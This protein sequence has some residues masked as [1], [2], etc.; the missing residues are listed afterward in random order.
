MKRKAK[1]IPDIYE[2]YVNNGRSKVATAKALGV[3]F[4]TVKKNLENYERLAEKSISEQLQNANALAIQKQTEKLANGDDKAIERQFKYVIAQTLAH[5][6]AQKLNTPNA[7]NNPLLQLVDKLQK[8]LTSYQKTFFEATQRF[9]GILSS[10][11]AGKT[12]YAIFETLANVSTLN[13]AAVVW[14]VAP[15]Y[16]VAKIAF[17]RISRLLHEA[18]IPVAKNLAELQFTFGEGQK[19]QFKSAENPDNLYGEDVHFV[20]FDEF[21][22]GKEAAWTAIYS[23]L[24]FTQGRAVLIGN[25]TSASNW[26]VRL[27]KDRAAE[28]PNEYAFFKVT[29]WEAVEA[30]VLKKEVVEQA[31]KDLHKVIF[32]A[33]YLVEGSYDE[34]ALISFDKIKSV[35]VEKIEKDN[36][37]ELFIT[38]DIALMGS[39][40]FVVIV[41][42]GFK[43]LE[44]LMRPKTD[45]NE[46]YEYIL[47]LQKKY[48][49]SEK[50]IAYDA[51]GAGGYLNGFLKSS[52]AFNGNKPVKKYAN[53]RTKCYFE[54]SNKINAN[55]LQIQSDCIYENEIKEELQ[56]I[57]KAALDFEGK[58]AIIKK[59]RMREI[60]KRSPDFADALMMRM[61][62]EISPKTN[63]IC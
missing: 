5:E 59:D 46:V 61:Y 6:L 50:N 44:I 35:F 15:T 31:Q 33:L 30:G 56:V 27:V 52:L 53:L 13:N 32:D 40:K 3:D 36:N 45:G 18:G 29:A 23:T 34:L 7:K 28:S 22:R 25:F 63:P 49:V 62:F 26:G 37:A 14:W 19:L 9:K 12:H 38:A 54:L 2:H 51:D 11:K 39:D 60:I 47:D 43:V 4:E 55:Q 21:T 58:F 20:V 41:W 48:G 57:K 1:I 24:T 10:T 8:G 42:S 17:A 16:K